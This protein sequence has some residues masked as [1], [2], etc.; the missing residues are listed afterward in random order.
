MNYKILAS[1]QNYKKKLNLAKIL[2]NK[3][4]LLKKSSYVKVYL[5]YINNVFLHYTK[6]N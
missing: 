4:N 1:N 2:K 5:V 3:L 6:E